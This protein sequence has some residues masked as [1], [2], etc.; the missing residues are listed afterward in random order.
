[1]LHFFANLAAIYINSTCKTHPWPAFKAS[2]TLRGS[3][4]RC[5]WPYLQKARKSNFTRMKHFVALFL[6][7]FCLL[8]LAAQ[9]PPAK[10]GKIDKAD[11]AMTDCAFDPGAEACKLIDKR[12]IYYDRGSNLLKMVAERQTRIKILKEKGMAYADVHIPYYS[13]NND[14]RISKVTAYTYNLGADGSVVVTEVQKAHKKHIRSRDRLSDGEGGQ[15][16]R[17]HLYA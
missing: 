10:P 13:R 9:N 16:D 12:K 7:C 17:I 1:M 11:L 8:N 14:E 2:Q 5:P 15:R 6:A 3:Q 4:C